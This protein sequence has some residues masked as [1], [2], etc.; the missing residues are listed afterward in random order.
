[1]TAHIPASNSLFHCTTAHPLALL[2]PKRPLHGPASA[3][4]RAGMPCGANRVLERS[5]GHS[6]RAAGSHEG[7]QGER[8]AP[9]EENPA[10]CPPG[11][12]MQGPASHPLPAW[13]L[14]TA[15]TR[16][17]LNTDVLVIIFVFI[18]TSHRLFV[19][20]ENIQC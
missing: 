20:Q 2:A 18:P 19:P 9:V 8:A 13:H 14:S 3:P 11:A 12:E 1:M 17:E 6:R 4:Q 10:G 16:E 7:G 5:R 15:S